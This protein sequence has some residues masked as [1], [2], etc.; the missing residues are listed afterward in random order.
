MN[1]K[2]REIIFYENHFEDFFYE[3]DDKARDKILWTFNLIERH[4]HVPETYLKH[5][6]GTDGLYE[7]RV[8]QAN[9]IYR[10]FC[11]FWSNK[12]IVVTSGFQKK[13]TKTPKR[14]LAKAVLLKKKY[15]Q[16]N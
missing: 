2:V 5:L 10:I 9:N 12:C 4:Q 15:E 13:T 14:E 3:Q 11:F 7:I 1:E 16:E 8:Q 6:S